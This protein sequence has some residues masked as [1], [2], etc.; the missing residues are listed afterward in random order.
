MV[1]DN[2]KRKL[3]ECSK[4]SLVK[5]R[6]ILKNNATIFR[7]YSDKPNITNHFFGFNFILPACLKMKAFCASFIYNYFAEVLLE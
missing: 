4:I 3:T 2:L 6:K 5:L 7:N 1:A